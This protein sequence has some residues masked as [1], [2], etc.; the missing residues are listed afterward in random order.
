MSFSSNGVHQK[1]SGFSGGTKKGA[2][3]GA[4]TW[5][6]IPANLLAIVERLQGVIIENIPAIELLDKHDS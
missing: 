1:N 3:T 6:K 5:A 4:T 2:T